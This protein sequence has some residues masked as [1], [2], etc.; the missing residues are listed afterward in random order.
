MGFPA[1]SY[2]G[3]MYHLVGVNDDILQFGLSAIDGTATFG[4][5]AVKL[6]SEGIEIW[7]G[8]TQVGSWD[9]NGNLASGED[10]DT[11]AKNAFQIFAK[12]TTYN[13]ELFGAGDML[14]GD[15][16]TGKPNLHWDASI[17]SFNFRTGGSIDSSQSSAALGSTIDMT[18]V[19]SQSTSYLAGSNERI[20]C[21]NTAGS[22]SIKLPE[23]PEAGDS[24]EVFGSGTFGWS[25]VSNENVNSQTIWHGLVQSRTSDNSS[26]ELS[27]ADHIKANAKY[28]CSFE[29]A[30]QTWIEVWSGSASATTDNYFG[31]GSDGDI[32]S[33]SDIT[34][35]SVED[36][37][38]LVKEY[39]QLTVSGG[40]TMTISDRCKGLIIAVNGD[41]DISGILTMTARGASA[42]PVADGVAA[43]GLRFP[44]LRVSGTDSFSSAV[45]TGTGVAAEEF[46]GKQPLIAGDGTIYQ[47]T[48]IGGSGGSGVYTTTGNPGG[49]L[50]NGVGG[51]GGGNGSGGGELTTGGS[52]SAGTCFSGGTGG[53]GRRGSGGTGDAGDSNGGIGGHG[54]EGAFNASGGAGNPGGNPTVSVDADSGGDG[55]GGVL[56]LLIKGNL[57]GTG[58]ISANGV[59]GGTGINSSASGGSSGAGRIIILYEGTNTFSGTTTA[60][61]GNVD[62]G[63]G[64]AGA[65]TIQQ[66]GG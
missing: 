49:T 36:G 39:S 16:S 14:I 22:M 18:T 19:V 6:T 12:E 43:D 25:I 37:D 28:V 17:P 42:D 47:T 29:G 5:G 32:T 35:T 11:P 48:R 41:C 15:N 65:I 4:A 8:A 64:G 57:S 1:F 13:G 56:I 24:I 7:N 27:S 34:L 10:L 59:N 66:V 51:G 62:S 33:S 26:I 38:V 40:D 61:G 20:L 9:E 31:D 30:D 58:T 52:G 54:T 55:T 50:T 63:D 2:Q 60:N 46:M 45:Y 21:T 53:G 3:V 44:M 23:S